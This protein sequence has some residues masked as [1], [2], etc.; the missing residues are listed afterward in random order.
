[1]C[2]RF[3]RST[4]K[5]DL[6]SRFGFINPRDLALPPRYN[7]APTQ[8]CPN[9]VVKDDQRELTMMRWG[10]VP[11]WAKDASIGYKMIN[12]RGETVAKLPSFKRPFRERRCLVLASGFYEWLRTDKKNKI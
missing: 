7:I 9:V 4:D 10:L 3:T 8:N 11:P 1:M 5:D 12:A 2:G 6:Q